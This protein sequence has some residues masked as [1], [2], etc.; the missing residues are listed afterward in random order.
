[1]I[2]TPRAYS[3]LE[4]R[5]PDL[6]PNVAIHVDPGPYMNMLGGWTEQECD[7]VAYIVER[8]SKE[9]LFRPMDIHFKRQDEP[10]T[11]LVP[12]TYQ[13]P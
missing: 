2:L 13:A 5:L 7:Q 3:S 11:P 9:H 12:F 8:W 6:P 1:M 10:L 4:G